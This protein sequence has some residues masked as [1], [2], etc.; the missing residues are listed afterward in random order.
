ME[1]PVQVINNNDFAVKS[2]YGGQ[3]YLFPP[4]KGVTVELDAVKHMFGWGADNKSIAYLR[5]GLM[6]L[7][8][9]LEKAQAA[10]DRFQFL[11]GR[12]VFDEIGGLAGA[13]PKVPGGEPEASA[14]GQL[15]DK[16]PVGRPRKV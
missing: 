6:K 1:A 11:E 12:T 9:P 3:D 7:G 10:Y 14:S 8:D 13:L 4:G 15:P 2:R 16:R 5:L